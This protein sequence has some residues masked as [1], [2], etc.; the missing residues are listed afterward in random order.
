MINGAYYKMSKLQIQQRNSMGLGIE[1]L[2]AGGL[3]AGQH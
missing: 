2:E 1:V 3:H